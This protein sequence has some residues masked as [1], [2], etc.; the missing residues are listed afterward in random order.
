MTLVC[1][2]YL[3]ENGSRDESLSYMESNM[4]QD[5]S[6]AGTQALRLYSHDPATSTFEPAVWDN[7]DVES[8]TTTD[9]HVA[10]GDPADQQEA[11]MNEDEEMQQPLDIVEED[12]RRLFAAALY[13]ERRRR[14]V[15]L[16]NF[17]GYFRRDRFFTLH[18]EREMLREVDDAH[19]PGLSVHQINDMNFD[20]SLPEKHQ[21]LG[22]DLEVNS[23]RTVHLERDI[24]TLPF[25]AQSSIVLL[26]KQSIP[27]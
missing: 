8:E 10:S 4:E 17:F 11:V 15:R 20:T 1:E 5:S 22:E 7:S 24:V 14:N 16:Q 3:V 27:M 25:I 2:F 26:P 9:D 19:V 12:D 6:I 13:V 21:Y 23:G 18:D